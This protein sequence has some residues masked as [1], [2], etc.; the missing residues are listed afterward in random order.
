MNFN[1]LTDEQI[2]EYMGSLCKHDEKYEDYK[3]KKSFIEEYKGKLEEC[4]KSLKNM[5]TRIDNIC[6]LLDDKEYERVY[7]AC[8]ET[9]TQ[10]EKIGNK[11]KLLPSY[12]GD[13]D[14]IS[15]IK[16][17]YETRLE[18]TYVDGYMKIILPELLPKRLKYD[19]SKRKIVNRV[20]YDSIRAGYF[21]SFRKEFATG[22][23]PVYSGRVVA[24]IVNYFT[25]EVEVNDADNLDP[26]II[27]DTICTFLL[28]DDS[29]I[30]CSLF[31]EYGIADIPHTEVTVIPESTWIKYLTGQH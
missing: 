3:T 8:L 5:N 15:K 21:E 14:N 2:K 26:K 12:F 23:M 7:D 25:S 29:M 28:E 6:S 11:F 17:T 4:R 1:K 27:I 22:R 16:E 9:G 19:T 31:E 18:F 10:I 13:K 24:H 30:Y 20:N